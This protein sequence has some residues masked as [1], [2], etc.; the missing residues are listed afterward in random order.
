MRA[1]HTAEEYSARANARLDHPERYRRESRRQ[2]LG[3]PQPIERVSCPPSRPILG[4]VANKGEIGD[5]SASHAALSWPALR[6]APVNRRSTTPWRAAGP[7]D[8]HLL[9]LAHGA[10]RG[11]RSRLRRRETEFALCLTGLDPAH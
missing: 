1:L 7:H 10:L 6:F 5:S 9:H 3:V 4:S 8:R 2:W 11:A